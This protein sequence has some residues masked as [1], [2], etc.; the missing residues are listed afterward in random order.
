MRWA[1]VETGEF[2]VGKCSTVVTG[3]SAL[4]AKRGETGEEPRTTILSSSVDRTY[5]EVTG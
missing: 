4:S 2:P 5:T 1:G 3:L